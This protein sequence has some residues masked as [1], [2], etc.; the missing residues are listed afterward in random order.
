MY[1]TLIFSDSTLRRKKSPI[2]GSALS[3]LLGLTVL[4][5][6]CLFTPLESLYSPQHILCL[7]FFC[8]SLHQYSIMPEGKCASVYA[9]SWQFNS[10]ISFSRFLN[11]R[12]C[13][14][15]LS[16]LCEKDHTSVVGISYLPNRLCSPLVF[17]G[18][19]FPSSIPVITH[20]LFPLHEC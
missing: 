7:H 11:Y 16:E 17:L 2:R 10:P 9:H 13:N 1:T 14:P 5:P 3:V 15:K 19:R 12:S 18:R 8:I 4:A 20:L 6:H